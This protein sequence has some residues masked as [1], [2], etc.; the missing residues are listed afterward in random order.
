[1]GAAFP[2]GGADLVTRIGNVAIDPLDATW[3]GG[4]NIEVHR[5]TEAQQI[6]TAIIRLSPH[7][8]KS[9]QVS[10]GLGEGIAARERVVKLTGMGSQALD[11]KVHATGSNGMVLVCDWIV[12]RSSH[13]LLVLYEM[14]IPATRTTEYLQAAARTAWQ[15]YKVKDKRGAACHSL[16]P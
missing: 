13:C 3:N 10:N 8:I 5:G 12:I 15:V 1:M 4:E 16:P 7:S 6:M 11:V 2:R 14:L 9:L